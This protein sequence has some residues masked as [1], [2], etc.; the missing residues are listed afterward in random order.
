MFDCLYC[1]EQKQSDEFSLEH[2]IPQF[3]GGASTPSRFH[4]RNV[5]TTCNNRLGLFVDASYAKAWFT[6]NA[7]AQAARLLCSS[8]N[9]P[10]LP[11]IHMGHVAI[12]GLVIPERHVAEYWLGPSGESIVW[13]RQHD[14]RMD[15]YAGGN[16]IDARRAPSVFYIAPTTSDSRHLKVAMNSLFRLAGKVSS[17]KILCARLSDEDGRPIP[18]SLL[19][20]D[21]PNTAEEEASSAILK[22]LRSGNIR[23]RVFMNSQFDV[24]F[25]CK[26]ALGVGFALFGLDFLAQPFTAELR[27]GVWPRRYEPDPLICGISSLSKS[28]H[29]IGKQLHYAGT[30]TLLVMRTGDHWSLTLVVEPKLTFSV[31]LGP[32]SMKGHNIDLN[33]GYALILIPYLDKSI[34]LTATSFISHRHGLFTHPDLLQIDQRKRKAEKFWST[35]PPFTSQ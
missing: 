4:L 16:P 7:L 22:Q 27:R 8:E 30:V 12:P 11:L 15:S 1:G 9:D 2:A 25:I 5:C 31:R 10:G 17:R 6:T 26:L 18:S 3:L 19:G 28:A 13:V 23:S 34:E 24:R 35:Q 32:I 33:D 20:F 21:P 14:D 29:P